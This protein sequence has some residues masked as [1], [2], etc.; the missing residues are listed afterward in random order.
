MDKSR[1][2]FPGSFDP[3]TLGHIDIINRACSLFEKVYVVIAVNPLKSYLFS[4]EERKQMLSA[5]FEDNKKIEVIVWNGL[6]AD[7]VKQFNVGVIVRGFRNDVDE[8]YEREL[9]RVYKESCP[10]LDFLLLKADPKFKDISSTLVKE[11]AYKGS[12]L[13]G[14]VPYSVNCEV[15]KK[16][17]VC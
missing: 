13:S 5:V 15:L 6:T 2:A 11:S 14:F 4:A 10:Q 7:F 17:S 9:C 8:K 16:I 3:P 12:D 1:A